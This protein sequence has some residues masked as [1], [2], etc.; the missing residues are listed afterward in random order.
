MAASVCE[1]IKIIMVKIQEGWR[2][3]SE[4][5]GKRREARGGGSQRRKWKRW[6]RWR[7]VDEA[8]REGKR[9]EWCSRPAAFPSEGQERRNRA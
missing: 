9:R 6:R 8:G 2:G 4:G 3:A 7:A 5:G 1:M